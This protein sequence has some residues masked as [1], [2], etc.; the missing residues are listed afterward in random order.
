MVNRQATLYGSALY[1]SGE[2]R[3]FEDGRS[4]PKG[5]TVTFTEDWRL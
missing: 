2:Q 5:G 4:G 3:R 1:D